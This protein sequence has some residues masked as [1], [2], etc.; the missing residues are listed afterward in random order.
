MGAL[1]GGDTRSGA[2]EARLA[3]DVRHGGGGGHR[4]RQRSP[5]AEGPVRRYEL[6]IRKYRNRYA[7]QNQERLVSD[8]CPALR[9]YDA[10]GLLGLRQRGRI[11]FRCRVAVTFAGR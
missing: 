9:R 10:V 3:R 4:L 5:Q 11:R 2:A 6:S 8:L 7:L 1:G